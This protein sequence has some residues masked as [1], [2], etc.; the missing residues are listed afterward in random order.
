MWF[1]ICDS[2]LIQTTIFD[3]NALITFVIVIQIDEVV[4]LQISHGAVDRVDDVGLQVEAVVCNQIR[5]HL[6]HRFRRM[7]AGR[8]RRRLDWRGGFA[9]DSAGSWLAQR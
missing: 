9:F 5:S 7:R 4:P 8:R 6:S 3:Q 2:I 1:T